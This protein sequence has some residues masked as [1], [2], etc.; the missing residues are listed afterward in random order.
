MEPLDHE[1]RRIIGEGLRAAAPGPEVEARGLARLLAAL[2]GPGGDG[3][4]GGGGA[5][6]GEGGPIDAAPLVTG[7]AS[8]LGTGLKALLIAGGVTAGALGVVAVTEDR[9]PPEPSVAARPEVVELPPTPA[10][11]PVPVGEPAPSV[12]PAPAV[13]RPRA[14]PTP[15]PGD[16]LLAETL[17]VAEADGALARGEYA[18]ARELAAA[19][20]RTYPE[21]Q[22]ALEREAIAVAAR[23]GLAEPDAAAVAREFLRAHPDAAVSA[24]VAARCREK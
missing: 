21:G 6:G 8:A 2:P 11:E 12:V 10:V 24:K 15:A 16:P 1:L 7:K 14:S 5:P 9:P 3:D 23:C 4:D 18:R 19:I 20:A 17:A 13:R 22:L